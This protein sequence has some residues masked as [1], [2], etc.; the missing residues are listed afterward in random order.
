MLIAVGV[1][2]SL[3]FW[4]VR[5]LHGK[6]SLLA[7]WTAR[8]QLPARPLQEVMATSTEREYRRV[9]ARGSYDHEHSI[10]LLHVRRANREG[11]R[12]L[13]PLHRSDDP[14][15]PAVLVDRGWIPWNLTD[16][17]LD[18]D[19]SE[20]PVQVTGVLRIV[21][22]GKLPAEETTGWRTRW[23]RLQPAAL[24]AQLPYRLAPL[25]LFRLDDGTGTPPL[26][27]LEPPRSHVDHRGYA[28]TWFSM[29]AIAFGTWVGM[30]LQQG[31]EAEGRAILRA[32]AR[33]RD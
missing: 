30:G 28:I 9:T 6:Q 7:E 1:L 8:S 23:N 3:G 31:R 12:V 17:F 32:P 2:T 14:D 26:A 4:Q 27:G 25:L 22:F 18:Q 10:L 11:A 29:A 24:Q 33:R 15:G 5:R 13:T 20:A 19:R 21:D 16:S